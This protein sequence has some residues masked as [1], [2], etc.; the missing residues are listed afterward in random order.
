[1]F[2]RG[3]CLPVVRLVFATTACQ[4]SLRIMPSRCW[5][6]WNQPTALGLV[7]RL[8]LLEAPS[9]LANRGGSAFEFKGEH[10]ELPF[11]KLCLAK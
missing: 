9:Y 5:T 10:D 4:R 11:G 7:D 2:Y 8:V 3:M 1:K 6:C